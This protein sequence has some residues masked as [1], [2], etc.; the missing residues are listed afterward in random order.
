MARQYII[1]EIPAEEYAKQFRRLRQ[2]LYSFPKFSKNILSIDHV[3]STAVPG[4]AGK[5]IIDIAVTV[6]S[7]KNTD[8]CNAEFL[9][10]GYESHGELVAPKSRFFAKTKNGVRLVNMHVFEK[11]HEELHAM[12]NNTRYLKEHPDV[13]AEYA[14]LKKLLYAA[15]PNDYEDY[16]NGKD[17]FMKKLTKLSG[18]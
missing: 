13:A 11:G 16:R 5:P 6:N 2:E 10:L 7:L 15:H 4:L 9:T 1:V 18:L 3:G 12:L 8:S 17:A 14:E